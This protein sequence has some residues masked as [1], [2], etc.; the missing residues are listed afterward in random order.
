[1]HEIPWDKDPRKTAGR[2]LNGDMKKYDEVKKILKCIFIFRYLFTKLVFLISYRFFFPV[3][4]IS[5]T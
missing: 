2:T 1:M 5:L 4:P 3:L